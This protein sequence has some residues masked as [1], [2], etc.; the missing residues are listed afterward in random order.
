[1][2]LSYRFTGAGTTCEIAVLP[3]LASK[4]GSGYWLEHFLLDRQ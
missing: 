2:G 1:M 4:P 3:A